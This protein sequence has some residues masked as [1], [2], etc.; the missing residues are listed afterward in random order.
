MRTEMSER[1]TLS[2]DTIFYLNSSGD[3]ERAFNGKTIRA[4]IEY[5]PTKN[6]YISL[7]GRFGD[8]GMDHNNY[9][10][11]E[12]YTDPGY[13]PYLYNSL[14]NTT[15]GGDYYSMDLVYQHDFKSNDS[16]GSFKASGNGMGLAMHNIKFEA[17]YQHRYN[18]EI[19][20]NEL[21]TLSDSVTS[22]MKSIESGPM[23]SLR[24]KLDYVLP[25]GDKAKLETGL[26]SRISWSTDITELYDLNTPG[27][28]YI[29]NEN[30][31]NFTEYNR[32][33]FA[34]Y[35]L[36]AGTLG[37]WGYQAGLRGEYTYRIISTTD[38]D[39]ATID[40]WDYFPTLH[41]SYNLPFDQQIM[42][43]YSRRIDRPRGWY[44][45]PF[46]TWVDEYNVRQGNPE[47]KPEYIDSY[48]LGYLKK[49]GDD[50]LS[51]EAY[52]R[53]TN[54]KVERI[55][56]VYS[57]DVIL[58][59]FENVGNDYSLGV[60]AM[61]NVSV[62]RWWDLNVSGNYYY[63]K[64]AGSLEEQ[65]FDRTSNN[66]NSRLNNTFNIQ[67]NIQFQISSRYNSSTVSAQGKQSAYYTLDAAMKFNFLQKR[68]AVNLQARDILGTSNREY[69]SSG[70]DFNLY[71]KYEPVS[72]VFLV[73][74]TYRFNNYNP[75]KAVSQEN[76]GGEEF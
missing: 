38:Q 23:N 3:A 73:T 19:T 40:R 16:L 17:S 69:T 20:I 29:I 44:L 58:T 25:L 66:W 33:I 53:I 9:L 72:P 55:R 67:K 28:D 71:S 13:T 65:D 63:Y 46:V 59:T 22:G 5:N 34:A 75:A 32:N 21:S 36:Y 30:Y 27:N 15:R 62:F 26:Q 43:S 42:A 37:D 76:G 8:W 45:E 48:D 74:L 47:L 7:A 70:T 57:E 39:D 68:L 4:G 2:N 35:A 64:I 41:L 56:S 18:D 51:L 50:F 11:Y 10:G 1:E 54:N 14:S 61:Y 6:D 12:S 49:F 31:S 52:Y 60:E 24:M